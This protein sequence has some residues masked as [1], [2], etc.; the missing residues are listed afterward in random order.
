MYSVEISPLLIFKEMSLSNSEIIENTNEINILKYKEEREQLINLIRNINCLLDFNSQ[1]FFLAL[2]YMDKIF[3]KD[4]FFIDK[5]SDYILLSLS[6]LLIASKFNENDPHV[7]EL[8]KYIRLCEQFSNFEFFFSIDDLRKGEMI[9]LQLLEFKVNYFSLYH[10]LVFFFAHGIIFE[11]TFNRIENNNSFTKRKVLEKIYILSR[12]ILD[13]L[14]EDNDFFQLGN[15]NTNFI[16]SAEILKFSIE[17]ILNINL[18]QSENIFECIYHIESNI[19]SE[20]IY[21]KINEI[22]EEKIQKKPLNPSLSNKNNLNSATAPSTEKSEKSFNNQFNFL[23]S[24]TLLNNDYHIIDNN[25]NIIINENIIKNNND[26]NNNIK[27]NSNIEDTLNLKLSLNY[28]DH[29]FYSPKKKNI[30]SSVISLDPYS[31]REHRIISSFEMNKEEQDEKIKG[32]KNEF[33]EKL[34]NVKKDLEKISQNKKPF[35]GNKY[36]SNYR[37]IGINDLDKKFYENKNIFKYKI[38]NGKNFENNDN[39]IKKYYNLGILNQYNIDK[40]SNI[41]NINKG[42]TYYK[43]LF[44]DNILNKIKKIFNKTKTIEQNT[45]ENFILGKNKTINQNLIKFRPSLYTNRINLMLS[46]NNLNKYIDDKK[47]KGMY[48]SWSKENIDFSLKKEFDNLNKNTTKYNNY[49]TF[50]DYGLERYLKRSTNIYPTKIN[51][52]NHNNN[53]FNLFDFGKYY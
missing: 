29:D 47:L 11:E 51:L 46:S 38:V 7:P 37:D 36:D 40:L 50:Y 17:K 5:K 19:E 49:G 34:A 16:V 21:G 15:T 26:I 30:K 41:N 42:I 6:C 20:F 25:H 39:L 10:F 23:N 52:I 12:G 32:L 28:Y 22:Y 35:S 44:S 31:Y 8:S 45:N 27:I 9:V 14:L 53:K 13:Y 48:S 33:I 4:N 24:N 2:F 43:N 3:C 18:T 1:T